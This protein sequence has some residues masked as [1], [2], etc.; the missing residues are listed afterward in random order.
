MA[1]YATERN[2]TGIV[3]NVAAMIAALA[4]AD[5]LDKDAVLA[6]REPFSH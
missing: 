1:G 2:A 5:R 6:I 4:L 3:G